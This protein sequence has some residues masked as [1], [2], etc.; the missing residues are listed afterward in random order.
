MS[1]MAAATICAHNGNVM[2][3]KWRPRRKARTHASSN[4]CRLQ[5][6]GAESARCSALCDGRRTC[7]A[8][9]TMEGRS[10]RL[11]CSRTEMPVRESETRQRTRAVGTARHAS[12]NA[13]TWTQR[14]PTLTQIDNVSL[15]EWR[16]ERQA[17]APHFG[18]TPSLVPK[19][20]PN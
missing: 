1:D 13:Q 15:N 14:Q 20:V 16:P 10:L 3:V 9:A 18:F 5:R 11:Q 12:K 19:V 8:D 2:L 4:D 6:K 7:C 17:P